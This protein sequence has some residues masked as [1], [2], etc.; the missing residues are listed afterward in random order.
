MTSGRDPQWLRAM[1]R[2]L[3]RGERG[4]PE[5][6]AWFGFANLTAISVVV[7][8]IVLAAWWWI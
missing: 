6:R 1:Q 4:D 3:E 2:I 5:A 8:L 7:V